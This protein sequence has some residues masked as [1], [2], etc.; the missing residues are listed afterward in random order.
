MSADRFWVQRFFR[1]TG[2][3]QIG[4]HW[5]VM[6][7]DDQVAI[8]HIQLEQ[9]AQNMCLGLNATLEIALKAER[10]VYDDLVRAAQDLEQVIDENGIISEK[11]HSTKVE[12]LRSTLRGIYKLTGEMA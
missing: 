11:M 2:N 1:S 4:F 8:D 9:I 12:A 5:Q 10:A 3:Q 6:T 7:P